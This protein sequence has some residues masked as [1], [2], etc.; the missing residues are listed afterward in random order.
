ML[1]LEKIKQLKQHHGFMKYFKN[2]SWLFAE[3]VL[4]VFVGIFK[5]FGLHG[6]WALNNLVY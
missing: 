5:A 6:T 3:K 1:F 2:T 4:R